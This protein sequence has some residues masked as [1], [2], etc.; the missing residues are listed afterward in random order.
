MP[1][2]NDLLDARSAWLENDDQNP[3]E[4]THERPVPRSAAPQKFRKGE[5]PY[6]QRTRKK[7]IIVTD[8]LRS[9]NKVFSLAHLKLQ[10][11]FN[12]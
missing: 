5:P 9:E 3:G 4:T 8:I 6:E 2:E 11:K 1:A 12:S 7:Q 10:I